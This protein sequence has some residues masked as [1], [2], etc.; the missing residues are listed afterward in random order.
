MQLPGLVAGL[1]LN[2]VDPPPVPY[3]RYDDNSKVRRHLCSTLSTERLETVAVVTCR[4]H[5]HVS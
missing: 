3:S 2:R 1:A 5:Q 4:R